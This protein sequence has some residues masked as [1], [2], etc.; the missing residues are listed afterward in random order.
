MDNTGPYLSYQELIGELYYGG[1]SKVTATDTVL[2]NKTVDSAGDV[3]DATNNPPVGAIIY[4]NGYTA[5]VMSIPA[6]G[7][8]KIDKTGA[9]NKIANGAAK[10]LVSTA[11][12]KAKAEDVIQEQMDFIDEQTGQFF[13]KR[14]GVFQ[15]EGNNT[16]VLFFPV[17]IIEID[18]LIINSSDQELF[19]G[20][21]KDF[22][23][24]KGRQRPQDDRRNP[25]IKM[26][27]GRGRDSIFTNSFSNR[28][29]AK[30][31]LT[32]I[33][34]A[35]GFLEPDGSTPKLIKRAMKILVIA[36]VNQPLASSAGSGGATG[37]LKRI[38]VDLHEKEF[39]E[40]AESKNAASKQSAS[41]DEEVDEILAKF[42]APLRIDGSFMPFPYEASSAR[43][44]DV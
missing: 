2:S 30:N 15:L 39:F 18:E 11:L 17:P 4:Q 35:F 14:A 33:T 22:F 41:G 34:G 12:P 36:Q 21:D 37:P 7:K 40:S 27:V 38:K 31:A 44:Y 5:E 32:K 8:I 29:F 10:V 24:F 23:A 26:N 28:V 42:K 20:E 13:N 6:A 19:E 1:S 9:A 25:R 16:P 3:Y 43:S